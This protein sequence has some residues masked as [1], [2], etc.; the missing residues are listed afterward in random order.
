[1]EYLLNRL[2]ARQASRHEGCNRQMKSAK[3]TTFHSWLYCWCCSVRIQRI[4]QNNA[5]FMSTFRFNHIVHGYFKLV[6]AACRPGIASEHYA[7]QSRDR[8]RSLSVEILVSCHTIRI[9]QGVF[10]AIFFQFRFDSFRFY[11]IFKWNI[12]EFN[13]LNK[14]SVSNASNKWSPLT[15]MAQIGTCTNEWKRKRWKF[16]FDVGICGKYGKFDEICVT[17]KPRYFYSIYLV[18]WDSLIFIRC[19][20][21]RRFLK[22]LTERKCVQCTAVSVGRRAQFK[23]CLISFNSIRIWICFVICF[24]RML[25]FRCICICQSKICEPEGRER[26]I[27]GDEEWNEIAEKC[28]NEFVEKLWIST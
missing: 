28:R 9:R 20:H 1:M 19:R 4:L 21:M 22:C 6:A 23:L 17:A 10:Y 5:F 18:I 2:G 8:C 7:C 3:S 25:L 14:C 16:V 13:E 15:T 26:T 12:N 24:C 27:D 11:W